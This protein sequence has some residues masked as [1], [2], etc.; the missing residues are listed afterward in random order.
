[1]IKDKIPD[2]TNE[3]E[4]KRLVPTA[5]PMRM[6]KRLNLK[7]QRSDPGLSRLLRYWDP[8]C[9]DHKNEMTTLATTQGPPRI[10]RPK[11]TK[12]KS[13]QTE[14]EGRRSDLAKP[15]KTAPKTK[16]LTGPDKTI[17]KILNVERTRP[18]Q[19]PQSKDNQR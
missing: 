9:K 18:P 3:H 6:P 7:A 19:V 4:T 14:T 16:I 1:M 5:R 2:Y 13:E 17:P 12:N 11:C 8:Q 15:D 10:K